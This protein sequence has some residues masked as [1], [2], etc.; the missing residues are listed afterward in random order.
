[1]K[2]NAGLLE[3]ARKELFHMKY[4]M[5]GETKNVGFRLPV[6]E[7][8]QLE[9]LARNRKTTTSAI[10]RDFVEDLIGKR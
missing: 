1:M 6:K 7:A 10:L 2:E 9:R 5:M 8:A 3:E 4:R